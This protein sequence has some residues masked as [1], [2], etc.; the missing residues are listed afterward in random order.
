MTHAFH[1]FSMLPADLIGH[2]S[3]PAGQRVGEAAILLALA[4]VAV[5]LSLRAR[6]RG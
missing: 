2:S 6:R 1:I 5:V 4:A 3:V